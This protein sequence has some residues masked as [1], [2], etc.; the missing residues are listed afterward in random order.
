MIEVSVWDSPF[1]QLDQV[2]HV[3]F[4]GLTWELGRGDGLII[5]GGESCVLAGC[6]V[7]KLGGDAVK[8]TGD[9]HQVLGCDISELGRGG[10]TMIGGDRK[11]LRSG[12]NVVENCNIHHLSRIDHTYT[13][14]VLF[15][16]VGIRVAH[17]LISHVNS[18]AMR[19]EGNDCIVEYNDVHHVV[20][21]SDDQGG[22]DMFGNP[23]YRGNVY[24]Y[25]YW[26]DIGNGMRCG[27]AGIRL[28]D[29]IS[30]T[31]IYGNVFYR[32]SDGGFG[33]VQIHGGKDNIVDNNLFIDCRSAIS[34][35]PWGE[36]R[37]QEFLDRPDV[38]KL[39]Y[40]QVDIT[41]PPYSSRYRE[42]ADL[43]K[44]V[45]VNR[46]WRNL[47][48]NCGQF[49]A[50]DRVGQ[51][52]M[53]NRT[54]GIDLPPAGKARE[55]FP[56]PLDSPALRSIGMRPIRVEEIGLYPDELRGSRPVRE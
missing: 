3:R 45:D 51:V 15:R 16:G 33:G 22:V 20:E 36:K 50:R 21:E 44:N 32:C 40:E 8:M 26:H 46:I 56:V 42:L 6:T 34:F 54:A 37:Y 7:R 23:G 2:S 19:I 14:A 31:L 9:R 47:A 10:I 27:Q 48:L 1:V 24:R 5:R 53:D 29:A 17:N 39:L 28:D 38:Q 49:L 25:N 52:L 11:T 13:P 43:T 35:S 55:N 30:G 18:S 12:E 4:R 41:K